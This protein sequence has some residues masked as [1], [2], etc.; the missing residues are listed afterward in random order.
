MIPD[1]IYEVTA[2]RFDFAM[3]KTIENDRDGFMVY[4]KTITDFADNYDI[5][6]IGN[7]MGRSKATAMILKD[8]L[9]LDKKVVVDADAL[10]FMDQIEE[11]N[12]EVI[13]TP[14]IKEMSYMTGI[15]TKDIINDPP[16]ALVSFFEKDAKATIILKSAR[17]II[18][19]KDEY[20]LLDNPTSKLAKGGSGD[21]LCGITAGM[22]AQGMSSLN[23]A[24]SAAYVHNKAAASLNKDPLSVIPDDII[25]NLD[26]IYR[27]INKKRSSF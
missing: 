9:K 18:A 26:N 14:H 19:N 20:Y 13:Y 12:A 10:F 15:S 6:T 1:I 17:S 2:K 7:G 23:A 24:I 5:I 3:I 21:I 27:M 22:W 11:I 8:I 25:E 4:D 16:K